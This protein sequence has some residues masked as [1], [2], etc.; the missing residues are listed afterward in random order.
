MS[1]PL[2][3]PAIPVPA[4]DSPGAVDAARHEHP[5]LHRR[6]PA[7]AGKVGKVRAR[8]VLVA[9]A[10]VT[11]FLAGL[12][13]PVPVIATP[14]GAVLVGDWGTGKVFRVTT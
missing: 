8:A 3:S 6:L 2:S 12:E 1:P 14:D 4:T 13:S 5:L 9:I 11:P 7:S 10:L